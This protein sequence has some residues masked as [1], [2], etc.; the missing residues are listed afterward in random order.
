MNPYG[1]DTDSDD[2]GPLILVVNPSGVLVKRKDHFLDDSDDND[3]DSNSD[4]DSDNSNNNPR[5]KMHVRAEES[6]EDEEDEEDKKDEAHPEPLQR[7][8]FYMHRTK[9]PPSYPTSYPMKKTYRTMVDVNGVDHIIAK[10]GQ[11]RTAVIG[12]SSKRR[13]PIRP[14]SQSVVRFQ[15]RYLKQSRFR[16]TTQ[17]DLDSFEQSNGWL[18]EHLANTTQRHT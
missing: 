5:V 4:S 14:F 18:I 8:P 17:Q 12:K 7:P 9:Q 3:S 11:P 15:R 16:A 13:K 6:E 10:I 2:D 1:D